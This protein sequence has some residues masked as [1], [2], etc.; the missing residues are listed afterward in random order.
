MAFF[1]LTGMMLFLSVQA[2]AVLVNAHKDCGERQI[3]SEKAECDLKIRIAE[4]E[5]S[6]EKYNSH[7]SRMKNYIDYLHERNASKVHARS[8]YKN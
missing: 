5:D 3:K 8:K 6:L 1:G 4:L 2:I 7:E